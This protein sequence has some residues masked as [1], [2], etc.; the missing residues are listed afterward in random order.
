MYVRG[1]L[2]HHANIQTISIEN[3]I[4]VVVSGVHER[5][6]I[7]NDTIYRHILN[8]HTGHPAHTGPTDM[9]V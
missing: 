7:A 9:I 6:F 5:R 8:P 3:G 1:V 4:S 2:I